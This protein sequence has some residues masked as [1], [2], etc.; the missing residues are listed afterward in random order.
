MLFR[1]GLLRVMMLS[2]SSGPGGLL[3]GIAVWRWLLGSES[4]IWTRCGRAYVSWA[5]GS[6]VLDCLGRSII[7]LGFQRFLRYSSL[8]ALGNP[9]RFCV[10]TGQWFEDV[11]EMLDLWT[12]ASRPVLALSVDLFRYWGRICGSA[13]GW[14]TDPPSSLIWDASLEPAFGRRGGS[15]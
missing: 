6:A 3:G 15:P 14:R 7:I 12:R 9:H 13:L 1:S 2:A 11:P 5:I 4:R 8:S 10:S